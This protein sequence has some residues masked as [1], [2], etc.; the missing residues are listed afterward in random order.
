MAR[1]SLATAATLFTLFAS[2]AASVHGGLMNRGHGHL[3]SMRHPKLKQREQNIGERDSESPVGQDVAAGGS[4]ASRST[5]GHGQHRRN[6]GAQYALVGCV[7]VG[8]PPLLTH[9]A[10]WDQTTLGACVQSCATSLSVPYAYAG[11]LRG[12]ECWC[13]GAD[14]TTE[15][16]V[17]D[18]LVQIEQANCQNTCAASGEK[19][20]GGDAAYQLYHLPTVEGTISDTPATVPDTPTVAPTT[21]VEANTPST[22]TTLN[23][24]AYNYVG[25]YADDLS[26]RILR[27]PVILGAGSTTPSIC[28]TYCLTNGYPFVGLEN[29]NE[30]FCGATT[31]ADLA[32]PTDGCTSPCAG[33]A[34]QTCGAPLRL[35]LY[36]ISDSSLISHVT[37]LPTS[38]QYAHIGCYIDNVDYRLLPLP[39]PFFNEQMSVEMCVGACENAGYRYAGLEA[40]SECFCGHETPAFWLRADAHDCDYSCNLGGGSCGGLLRLDVYASA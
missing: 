24:V 29:G 33:D 7:A 39:V 30:C 17:T 32:A 10:A 1:S 26:A 13:D 40:G 5:F 16:V 4:L 22:I 9:H 28:A 37:P 2:L 38:G 20:C 14:P 6:D 19:W 35:S 23:G 31:F 27:G 8:E 12:T 15:Q 11:I 21:P 36:T 34:T 3:V 18:N 25:C